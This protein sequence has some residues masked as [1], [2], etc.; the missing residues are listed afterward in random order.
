M[1]EEEK[2]Q[3]QKTEDP[4]AKRLEDARNKGPGFSLA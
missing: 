2:E 4:T 1:A 3:D